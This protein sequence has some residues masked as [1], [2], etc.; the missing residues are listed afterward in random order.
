MNGA[1]EFL[2]VCVVFLV[3]S[4]LTSAQPVSQQQ[5]KE[6]GTSEWAILWAFDINSGKLFIW[7]LL[8][9]RT[10][11][12]DELGKKEQPEDVVQFHSESVEPESRPRQ[13]RSVKMPYLVSEGN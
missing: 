12:Y 6:Q 11:V 7:F 13:E 8:L 3:I 10:D 9:P 4:C 5:Q 1:K 2:L